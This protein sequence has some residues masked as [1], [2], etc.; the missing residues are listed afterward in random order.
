MAD[1]SIS[2]HR[3]DDL[4]QHWVSILIAVYGAALQALSRKYAH[5]TPRY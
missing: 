1:H 2:I 4:V 3:I 5:I